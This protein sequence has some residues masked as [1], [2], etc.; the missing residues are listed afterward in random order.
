MKGE[1]RAARVEPAGARRWQ[2]PS[3]ETNRTQE[4]SESEKLE[5]A[6][7]FRDDGSKLVKAGAPA[8]TAPVV[9]APEPLLWCS[10]R[11]VDQPAISMAPCSA[12]RPFIA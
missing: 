3:W 8:F 2:V 12:A 5:V 9:K 11:Q 10:T 7:F 6:A 4:T 1:W